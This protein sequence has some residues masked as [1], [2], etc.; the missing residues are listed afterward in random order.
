[1]SDNVNVE[2]QYLLKEHQEWN[3]FKLSPQ[4]YFDLEENETIELDCVPQYAH[5]LDYLRE[6]YTKIDLTQILVTRIILIDFLN[7]KQRQINERFWFNSQ[8]R[9]IERIDLDLTQFQI[10]DHEI[11][12]ETKI[13]NNPPQWEILRLNQQNQM[14]N[15][16]FHSFIQ[17]NPDGSETEN[18]IEIESFSLLENQ[19]FVKQLV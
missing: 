11:I 6:Y 16:I 13:N 8:N 15:P 4:E 17:E 1:M 19:T 10:Q 14:I 12:I 2:I 5:A 3:C 18:Q 7:K 9:L